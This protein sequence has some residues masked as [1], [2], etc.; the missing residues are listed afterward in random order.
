MAAAGT[1]REQG[2]P[3]ADAGLAEEDVPELV[4]LSDLLHRRAGIGNG[5]EMPP[6]L[7]LA[8]RLTHPFKEV[9]LQDIGLERAAGFARHDEQRARRVDPV[10]KLP[11]LCRVGRIEHQELGRKGLAAEGL[12]EHLGTEA[13]AAH[14]E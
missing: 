9:L 5:D 10:L 14:A 3:A 12:R 4:A 2:V 8:H 7:L 13:G 1:V 11:D 6:G